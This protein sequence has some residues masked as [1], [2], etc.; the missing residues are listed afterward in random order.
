MGSNRSPNYPALTLSNAVAA[1]NKLW[2]SEKRTSVSSEAAALAMG[3]KSLSGPARVA[4]GAMRQYGLIDKAEKG[5]IRVSDL[6]VQILKGDEADRVVALSGAALNPPLFSELVNTHLDASE[7]AIRSYLITKKGFVDDGARKAA[8][9]FRDAVTLAT[10]ERSGYTPEETQE[11][12]KAMAGIESGQQGATGRA[13][14]DVSGVL[15]LKV[16]YG[17]GALAVEIRV[18]GEPLKRSHIA[19]VRRYLELAESDL[20][21]N[22]G[23]A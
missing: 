12:P 11:K 23:D 16:P 2:E 20:T 6:A 8:K 19:K 17:A 5:H 7:N 22:G 21:E 10:P 9:A 4:I 3:Y 18:T 13:T 15:S 1:V 14:T